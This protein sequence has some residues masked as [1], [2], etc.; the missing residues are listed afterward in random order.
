MGLI[1]CISAPVGR[2]Y[3][4]P[5]LVVNMCSCLLGTYHSTMCMAGIRSVVCCRSITAAAA[6]S[7]CAPAAM[8]RMVGCA[9]NSCPYGFLHIVLL[10]GSRGEGGR[11][12]LRRVEVRSRGEG[13]G[14]RVWWQQ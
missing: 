13:E 10:S 14:R 12:G 3:Q 5:G 6:H 4:S 1:A 11:G 7:R 8:L 2:T 9:V